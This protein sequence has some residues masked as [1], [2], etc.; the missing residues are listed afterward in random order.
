MCQFT[1]N[2]NVTQQSMQERE[3]E[4]VSRR[5]RDQGMYD[6]KR[7]AGMFL[8]VLLDDRERR[9]QIQMMLAVMFQ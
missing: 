5:V 4:G 7:I 9:Q 2:R 3:S 1:A 6:Y 8:K